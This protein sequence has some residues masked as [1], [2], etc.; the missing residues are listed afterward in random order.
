MNDLAIA[1]AGRS[2][3]VAAVAPNDGY[4]DDYYDD[5]PDDVQAIDPR[6][7]WAALYRNRWLIGAVVLLA[8][9]AGVASILLTSP[10]YRA[11]ASVQIDQQSVKVLGTE[12]LEPN[13]SSQDA[14][15][16][17]QTQ[18]DILK[19]RAL[20][21]TVAER[22]DLFGN[23][24][25]LTE[26]GAKPSKADA[27]EA[28]KREQVLSILRENLEVNL[29]RNSRVVTI[30]F[31][32]ETPVLAAKVANGFSEDFISSNLQRKF[33]TTSYSREF[34][35]KQLAATKAR[36]EQSERALIGYA[37][38][39]QLIDTRAGSAGATEQQGPQS[40]TTS[41]LVQLNQSYSQARSARI[42][43]QQRW[44]QA[45]AT[46]LM[47]LPEVLAN[48]TIQKL[49]QSRAELEAKY[50]E[51][52]QRRKPEHPAVEQ[53]AANIRELDRQIS[54]QAN[55]IRNSIRD[56]YLVAQ[57]QESALQGNVGQLKSETL[58]EQDRS[59]RYNILK[60]EV[61]TNRELYNGL[62]Q[63]F[64]EIS[65]QAGVTN[66]NISVID[67]A[68]A[69]LKPFA[70]R[71]ALNLALAG[72][73]GLA[74]A[75]M[76]VFVREKFDD[77]IRAPGEVEQKLG[78]PL[79]GAVPLLKGGTLADALDDRQSPIS[80]AYQSVKTAVELSSA[81]GVPATLLFTSSRPSEGKSTTSLTLAKEFARAGKRVVLIDADMRK[82]TLHRTVGKPNKIG[83]SNVLAHQAKVSD[84]IQA[85][86]TPRMDIISSGPFPPSPAEL[87]G[88]DM[89]GNLLAILGEEYDIV[90]IDGPPV[91]GLADAP[92]L[93]ATV[94]GTIFVVEANGAHRG[95]AKSALKRLQTTGARV[96]GAVLTKF[97]AKLAG[98][99]TAYDYYGFKYG[100]VIT[101]RA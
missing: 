49:T 93:A 9:L 64:K 36:L 51:E 44:A 22:L 81:V 30:A 32:S 13:V 63:R 52:R 28:A 100:E 55:S 87:L 24:R 39:A 10:T 71:P 89:L 41:N 20:A 17:L 18:V 16:F 45:Q 83:L 34:L 60:R 46:P 65:A 6:A 38:G 61:D 50:E 68:D 66:N 1:P 84:A 27:T 37:R 25:F 86:E 85:I 74:L 23:E 15:R 43:A 19:S 54:T 26:M 58:A 4:I 29:P 8:L 5:V 82:P 40:L 72:L 79:L 31:T 12:D 69:P 42:Q 92:R 67:R 3:R 73:A 80:E 91:L 59:I 7:L 88:S 76:L 57:R 96:I 77:A 75:L 47:S 11:T 97:D 56:Q 70:P 35:Q 90:L 101:D 78:L 48:D 99:S 53:A 94:A 14:E 98:Y 21:I 2:E 95:H 62:L 33:D